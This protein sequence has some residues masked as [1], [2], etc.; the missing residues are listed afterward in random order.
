MKSIIVDS[1]IIV[2]VFLETAERHSDARRLGSYFVDNNIVI[3]M[4]MHALFEHACALRNKKEKGQF[5]LQHAITQ[6][7]PLHVEFVAID[8][9]FFNDYYD[10]TLPYLRAGD[11][12]FLAMAAKDGAILITEDDAMFNAAKKAR[13]EVFRLREFLEKYVGTPGS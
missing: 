7:K 10:P 1:C 13:I 12:I 5:R 4:P 11:F 9:K 2:D 3:K 6:E 8:E